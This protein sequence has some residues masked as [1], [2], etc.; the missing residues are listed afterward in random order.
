[1]FF[2]KDVAVGE[3]PIHATDEIGPSEVIE[4]ASKVHASIVDDAA[5]AV[6]L[7]SSADD[8]G[9][10]SSPF[11]WSVRPFYRVTAESAIVSALEIVS[12]SL[13]AIIKLKLGFYCPVWMEKESCIFYYHVGSELPFGGIFLQAN[14]TMS[15]LRCLARLVALPTDDDNSDDNGPCANPVGPSYEYVPPR[16]VF[17]SV[18]AFVVAGFILFVVPRK[19]WSIALIAFALIFDA[20]LLPLVGHEYDRPGDNRDRKQYFHRNRQPFQHNL[21]SV[22]RKYLT[23]GNG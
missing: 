4:Q 3:I 17:F 11:G 9:R 22:S 21:I 12:G 13:P 10:F 23:A 16:H 19:H 18:F 14:G 2:P 1:M 8:A 7:S 15:R 6:E 5:K 20:G